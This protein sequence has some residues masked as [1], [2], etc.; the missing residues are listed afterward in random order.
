ME[1]AHATLRELVDARSVGTV[2]AQRQAYVEWA[3]QFPCCRRKTVV[4]PVE[5]GVWV[6][7]ARVRAGTG[8]CCTS[9]AAPTARLAGHSSGAHGRGGERRSGGGRVR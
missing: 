5:F 3:G 8:S 2:E 9:M 1:R 6:R 7:T 4:E